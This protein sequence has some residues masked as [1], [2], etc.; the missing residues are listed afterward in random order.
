MVALSRVRPSRRMTRAPSNTGTLDCAVTTGTDNAARETTASFLIANLQIRFRSRDHQ[1]TRSAASSFVDF[2]VFHHKT[3][4]LQCMDVDARVAFDSDDVGVEP[5]R[6]RADLGTE[7]HRFGG[8][9]GH[10][11][12]RRQRCLAGAHA[13][14][15]FAGVLAVRARH[16]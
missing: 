15:R 14:D 8:E 5:W 7:S 12:D 6:E 9:P 4:T 11:G 2:P 10:A 3:N 1:I 16:R 13:L